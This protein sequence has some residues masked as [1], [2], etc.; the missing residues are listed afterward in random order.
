MIH[1]KIPPS[2]S[3]FSFDI[4]CQQGV[5]EELTI[6]T[7]V[8]LDILCQIILVFSVSVRAT[9]TGV[10]PC[11]DFLNVTVAVIRQ[12]ESWLSKSGCRLFI[13]RMSFL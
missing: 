12:G 8:A 11:G 6:N 5:V 3:F 10:Y 9:I 2:P 1:F 7:Q 4:L 13:V